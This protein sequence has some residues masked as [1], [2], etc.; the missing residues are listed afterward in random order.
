MSVR[1]S[2]FSLLVG[3]FSLWHWTGVQSKI[4]QFPPSF[5]ACRDNFPY[6]FLPPPVWPPH[7]PTWKWQCRQRG[8][9]RAGEDSHLHFRLRPVTI[10]LKLDKLSSTETLKVSPQKTFIEKSCAIFFI[11][12]TSSNQVWPPPTWS[13]TV[14]CQ[15]TLS[16]TSSRLS[17]IIAAHDS[18]GA[19]LS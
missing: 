5:L 9:S 11:T 18:A 13:Y 1:S 7:S 14:G 4:N 19:G 8:R 6:F 2:G 15:V 12:S 3:L 16:A 17:P 10:F